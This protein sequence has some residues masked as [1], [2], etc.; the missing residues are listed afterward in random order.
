MEFQGVPS[1]QHV[2][3]WYSI[4][5]IISCS[6]DVDQVQNNELSLA[7]NANRGRLVIGSAIRTQLH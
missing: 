3:T 7:T 5:A 6:V 1:F 2:W 4:L